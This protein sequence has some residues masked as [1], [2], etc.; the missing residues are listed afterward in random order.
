MPL[1][2][3][4][5]ALR[6]TLVGMFINVCQRFIGLVYVDW[7]DFWSEALS[8]WV[9]PCLWFSGPSY[10]YFLFAHFLFVVHI[11]WCGYNLDIK[12]EP[13]KFWFK[14]KSKEMSLQMVVSY[15]LY[16]DYPILSGEL[17]WRCGPLSHYRQIRGCNS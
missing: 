13:C 12:C 11:L 9:V 17:V 2:Q 4:E 15:I 5:V 16:Y 10:A 6:Y 1:P 8:G 7:Y 3:L 14:L